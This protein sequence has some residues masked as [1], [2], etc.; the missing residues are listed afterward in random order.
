METKRNTSQAA[1]QNVYR[2]I[3][4]PQPDDISQSQGPRPFGFRER[5]ITVVDVPSQADTSAGNDTDINNIMAR[6]DRT[7]QL[8]PGYAEPR[9][10]DCTPFNRDLTELINDAK[11][12]SSQAQEFIST[13]SE[14]EPST[15]PPSTEPVTPAQPATPPAATT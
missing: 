13:W 2:A 12:V 7:G 15:P 4:R 8:P 14:P 3:A 5:Y 6:F 9:Y 10:E 1:T 11:A